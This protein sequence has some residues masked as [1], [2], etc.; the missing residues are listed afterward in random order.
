[1][2]SFKG[3]KVIFKVKEGPHNLDDFRKLEEMLNESVTFDPDRVRRAW[4]RRIEKRK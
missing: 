3:K 2:K 4:K 1:M